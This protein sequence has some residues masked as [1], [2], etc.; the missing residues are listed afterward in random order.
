MKI[1]NKSTGV[2]SVTCQDG[3]SVGIDIGATAVRAA[4]LEV[5]V[6][7]GVPTVTTQH[8]GGTPLPP[9]TVVN[10]VVTDPASLTAALKSLWR[11]NG[12]NCRNVIVGVANPQVLVRE[13]RIPHLEPE[14]QT[15]ALPFQAR[16][17]IALPMDQVVLDFTPLG[18]PDPDTNL[19]DG[20]LVASPREPVMSAV[21]AVERAGLKVARVDLSSFAVLRS[22][23]HD[24]LDVEAVIDLGAHLTTVVV[25]QR[26]IPQLVR[27]LPRGGEELTTRLAERL[28][29]S[30]EEAEEAK[31][32]SGLGLPG[33]VS[34]VL[35]DCVAPLLSEIRSSINYFR[36]G[37]TDAQLRGIALT[38]GGAALAGLDEVLTN[39]NGAPARV[40]N[41]LR[42]VGPATKGRSKTSEDRWASAMSVG[43]AMGTAA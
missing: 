30:L 32:T 25:H 29:L 8:L 37:H 21:A 9:G 1:R 36:T 34:A 42:L 22:S 14:Q 39:Q 35:A 40:S 15:R 38:G 41:P 24:D 26:G 20:L 4:V 2:R 16:D 33:E 10:G 12:I 23:A 27:T 31:C 28:N 19:V 7:D 5:E 13:I 3:H 17:V 11:A 6:R 18:P 43:L